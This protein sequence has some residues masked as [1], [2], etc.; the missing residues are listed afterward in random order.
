MRVL[1]LASYFPKPANPM[2]GT[3]A[4]QQAQAL[5]RAGIEL[6]TVSFTSWVPSWL[7]NTPGARAYANCPRE[8]MW[9]S[10]EVRYP[11]WWYYPIQ[12]FKRWAFA[13]PARQMDWAWRSARTQLL[14][15]VEQIK[16]E[17]VYVHHTLPNGYVAH[18]LHQETGLPYVITD[19]D[20]DEVALAER[21]PARR[22]VM[23]PIVAQASRMVCV[24]QRMERDMRRI[25]PAV[26]ASTVHNGIDLPDPAI[27]QVP[28]PQDLQDK[29]VLLCVA[30]FAP[31]KG[32]PLLIEAFSRV[33][34]DFPQAVLRIV[35]DGPDRPAIE[36]A[37]LTHRVGQRVQLIGRLTHAQV[38]QEMAWC[39]A[40]ALIGWDEPFAT[41]FIEA[42]G[43]GKALLCCN[44]GG[45]NDV[46][47]H[48]QHA[49]TVA[50]KDVNAAVQGLQ[51]L[52]SDA[53]LRNKLGTQA[54]QLVRE[55]LT[56]DAHAQVMREVFTEVLR[57][58]ALAND[59]ASP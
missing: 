36:L 34:H 37:M 4:L 45:I 1:F 7:A 14:R 33:M 35:G 57:H 10:L 56:W 19:H 25:F 43:S 3:W 5:Q 40:F 52:L 6:Q 28:R 42:M 22:R 29:T 39:D 48:E 31:R 47:V 51:R 9:G 12:P 27:K 13:Q 49:L 59:G 26:K 2:M 44:D 41:V 24:A 53:D 58:H 11:R 50:P 16:P 46:I 18:R 23:Q 8:H 30:L 55:Q 21:L 17:L 54:A 38:L 20:F 32:V 15:L